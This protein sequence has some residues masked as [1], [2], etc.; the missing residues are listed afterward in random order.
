MVAGPNAERFGAAGAQ[1]RLQ[2]ISEVEPESESQQGEAPAAEPTAETDELGIFR[3]SGIPA[4]C[5]VIVA[6]APGMIGQSDLFCLPAEEQPFRL[7]IEMQVEAVV[8]SV[9]VTASAITI[10][11]SETSSSGS[12][13]I[14]TMD[15]AP[16][17]NKRYEDVMPLIPGVLRGKEGEIN[18]NGV[19]AS[20]SGSQ[21]NSVDMTDPVARTSQFSLPLS[22][23]SNV[24]VLSTPYD[25][26]FGGFAGAVSTVE[27]K[28]ADL[29]KFNVDLQN[30]GPRIRRRDGAIMGIESFTPRL[31]VNV[32][33]KDG[34]LALLHS[35]EYQYVRADQEDANLPLLE[36]DVERETLTVFNQFDAR[37]SNRNRMSLS[38]L[39]YPEKLSYFG[40]NAFTTQL[41]TPDLRRRGSM[42][43]LRDTHEFQSGALLLSNISYQDLDNDV[44]PRTYD[45][46]FIGLERASGAFF[47][48]QARRTIRRNLSEQYHFAPL[49][50]HQIVTGIQWSLESYSGDQIFNPITWLGINDRV[51]SELDFTNPTTVH[52]NKN[53]LAT[54]VQDKWSL[55]EALTLDLGA[56][57]ERDSIAREWNPSYRAGF[58]YAF[59][60]GSRT[61]LRG[62]SGLFID[63]VSLLVPTF[64][65]LPVRIETRFDSGGDITS[66][67]RFDPHIDGKIRNARSFGWNLQLDHELIN[68]LFLRVGYQQRRTTRN[69]LIEPI[70]PVGASEGASALILSNNGRDHYR[71]YQATARYRLKGTGHIT[72]SY[73]RSSSVGD[74][75]DL[76]SIYG[77]TPL[78]LIRPNE[79]APLRFDVPHRFLAWMEFPLPFGLKGI[80]VWEVR[81]GFPYSDIDEHRDFVGARN[82]AGRF[83]DFQCARFPGVEAVHDQAAGQGAACPRRYTAFQHLEQ[84][85]S[86]GRAG[87]PGESVLRNLLSRCEAQNPR[88][89]RSGQLTGNTSELTDRYGRICGG[90]T[91]LKLR[92]RM[93]CT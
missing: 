92:D 84:F 19:R 31:T 76:G 86:A 43:T 20:Q 11:P 80:P 52:A 23:I 22:V 28:P 10:D 41:S 53:D 16:K 33:I 25:A 37:I 12:V 74:L 15:N 79:R 6:A 63:R 39:V 26:Q 83:P 75:N 17:A 21:L 40:L 4:G 46:S 44:K 90:S 9:E 82:R 68:D 48:R 71:E 24:Q 13:G 88:V 60:G 93:S 59:G 49:G 5:Y 69:F 57:F 58:A 72:A 87:K 38:V 78:A 85:Q 45:P 81:S 7:T 2:S 50:N 77:P 89:V 51:V 61:V 29:S 36:R 91:E 54:F 64:M 55:S 32:P 30:F 65:Q 34:R 47:N 35:T 42:V 67:R 66:L 3:F 73:V 8:E 1:I 56:R 70:V 18:L 27:T 14:S 62:G